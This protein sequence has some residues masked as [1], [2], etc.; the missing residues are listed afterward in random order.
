MPFTRFT[1]FLYLLCQDISST[2]TLLEYI[3]LFRIVET[4]HQQYAASSLLQPF[5][6]LIMFVKFTHIDTCSCSSFFFLC[7]VLF[8]GVNTLQP[9]LLMYIQVIPNFLLFKQCCYEFKLLLTLTKHGGIALC[10]LLFRKKA[11][12]KIM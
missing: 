2:V 6:Y 4:R 3:L 7:C 10:Q 1:N 12:L 11:T 9:I 5:L 8:S